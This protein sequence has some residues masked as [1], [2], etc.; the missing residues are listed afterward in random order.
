MREADRLLNSSESPSAMVVLLNYPETYMAES[1]YELLDLYE[2][3]Y[4]PGQLVEL[5]VDEQGILEQVDDL[6]TNEHSSVIMIP[7]IEDEIGDE[8]E[9]ILKSGGKEPYE[10][11]NTIGNTAYEIWHNSTYREFG[12]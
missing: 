12:E 4:K 10:V 2:I 11:R 8:I 3:P 7:W 5:N 9:Q 1:L 6:V